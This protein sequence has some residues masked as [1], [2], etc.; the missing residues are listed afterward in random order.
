MKEKVVT[1]EKELGEM[2]AS[3]EAAL[4]TVREDMV[5]R[6]MQQL[7][8]N[9][10]GESAMAEFECS[11]RKDVLGELE[12]KL[13]EE[14]HRRWQLQDRIKDLEVRDNGWKARSVARE[15]SAAMLRRL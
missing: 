15:H 4:A 5:L 13:K 11:L 6:L 2:D 1:S 7:R 10:L 14:Q 3:R 12:K 9:G 8:Q